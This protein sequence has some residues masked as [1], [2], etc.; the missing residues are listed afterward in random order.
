MKLSAVF[1]R[2]FFF[3]LSILFVTAFAVTTNVAGTMAS[4][5]LMGVGG[6]LLFGCAITF[7]GRLFE[8]FNLR[9]FNLAALGLL[10]GYLMGQAVLLVLTSILD[11][12]SLSL[13]SAAIGLMRVLVYLSCIYLSMVLTARAAEEISLSLPFFRFN[14]HA[15]KKKDI[16]ADVS[17]FL[18]PRIIDVAASGILD[19]NLVVPRVFLAD[20]QAQAESQDEAIRT[21][22]RRALEVLGK[23]E[24]MPTLGLRFTDTDIPDVKD[25]VLKLTGIARLIDANII[26]ADISRVQQP[27]VEGVRIINIHVLANSLKPVSQAGEYINI[28]IQRYGKEPRQGVGYLEDGTMVVINGGAAYIG[29]AIRARV[30]SVKHTSSGRMIFC[31]ATE[32]WG[33]EGVTS[34]AGLQEPVGAAVSSDSA[35]KKY[36]SV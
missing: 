25:P 19:Q 10:F 4:N 26:T 1:I 24:V 34:A 33:S 9:T 15:Q 13:D 29:E 12:S 30:L 7:L 16:L 20:L 35:S 5:V 8:R 17:I 6:G 3:L 11:V 31:N 32:E 36:Y 27:E 22:G 18:D 23:L 2:N 28:K 14:P 21:R